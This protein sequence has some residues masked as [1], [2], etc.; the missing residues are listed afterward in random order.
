MDMVHIR[1][2][3]LMRAGTVHLWKRVI[4]TESDDVPTSNADI[5]LTASIPAILKHWAN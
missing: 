1:L 3:H 4:G 2:K 5:L